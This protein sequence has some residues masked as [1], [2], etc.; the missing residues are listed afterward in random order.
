MRGEHGAIEEPARR[1]RPANRGWRRRAAL[2]VGLAAVGHGATPAVA[3][4]EGA[5][6]RWVQ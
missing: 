3:T 2:V 4:A 6:L 1:K 5:T